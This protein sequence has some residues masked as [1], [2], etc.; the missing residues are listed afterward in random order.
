MEG[1][2]KLKWEKM[3]E[4]RKKAAVENLEFFI[5]KLDLT[6]SQCATLLGI[7]LRQLYYFLSGDKLIP[8][9]LQL[10]TKMVR[11]NEFKSIKADIEIAKAKRILGETKN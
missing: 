9:T 7:T 8:E 10:L 6:R 2:N 11:D 3:I 4:P 1:R 5:E